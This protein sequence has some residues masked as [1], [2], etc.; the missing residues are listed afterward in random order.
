MVILQWA[1]PSPFRLH[2]IHLFL[3][4][5][6]SPQGIDIGVDEGTPVHAADSGVV[7]YSVADLQGIVMLLA[8]DHG[9]GLSLYAHNSALLV[10]KKENP[11][12]KEQVIGLLLEV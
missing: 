9:N 1:S 12:I 8:I 2:R 5:Y 4:N 7:I 3:D 11:Y 6:L 10:S